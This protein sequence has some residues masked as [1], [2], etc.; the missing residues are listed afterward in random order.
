MAID[1]PLI[2]L[3]QAGFAAF[4]AGL[5][6]LMLRRPAERWKLVDVPG[7]RKRHTAPVAVT[8]GIAMTA[9]TLIALA[10]S[11]DAF[12]QYAAFFW[13]IV[14]LALTGLLDDLGE[15]PAGTKMLVQV[16]AAV[17]GARTF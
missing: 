7:G 13:G 17:P 1:L 15:I 11:F 4:L 12:G 2:V 9:A 6:I 3:A 14:M 8:G 5:L 10:A 16:F